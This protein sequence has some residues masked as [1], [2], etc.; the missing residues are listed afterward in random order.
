[1]TLFDAAEYRAPSKGRRYFFTALGVVVTIAVFVAVFPDYLWY[2]FVYYKEINT[3]RHFAID[4]TQGN[5]QGAYDI[6]KPSAS[7]SFKD[8]SDDWGAGGYYGPVKSYRLGRP[9][10]IKNGSAAEIFL[11]VSPYQPFPARGNSVASNKTKTVRLWVE[12]RDQSISFP[13][14]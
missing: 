8:F 14:D 12:F 4:L 7:Y 3:V 2:P 5:M 11:D 13:P 9:E 6:W 1:L 10:H